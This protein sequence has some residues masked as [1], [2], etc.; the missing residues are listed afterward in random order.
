M[1]RLT[2]QKVRLA[3]QPEHHQRVYVVPLH[4]AF[5]RILHEHVVYDNQKL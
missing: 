1:K 2:L 5:G 4:G 3:Q